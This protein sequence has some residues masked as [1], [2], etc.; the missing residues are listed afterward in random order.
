MSDQPKIYIAGIGMITA[1]G[2]HTAMTAAAVRA[3]VSG[4]KA[5]DYLNQKGQPI[6]MARVPAEVFTSPEF[7]IDEGS[8]PSR[9]IIM[10]I[11]ALREALA[12]Q[13][14]QQPIPLILALPEKGVG[15]IEPETLIS[16]LLKQ[17][18]LPLRADRVQCIAGGRAAGIQGL[19]WAIQHLEQGADFVLLGGSDSY[20]NALRIQEL[21]KAGRL[22]APGSKD[23]F[24]PGEA[25]G[26]LLLT[27]HP[28][29]ALT[30]G[31]YIRGRHGH[32]RYIQDKYA[33]DGHPQNEHIIGLSA[34]GSS[35]EPGH[36][37][38][39]ESYRGDGLD[40]AFKQ[41]L[42]AYTGE[43]IRTIYS[44]M[45]GEHHWAKEYGVAFIRNQE[46]FHD[47]VH[48][49]HPADC[50]GDLGS[51]TGPIFIGLAAVDLFQLNQPGPATHLVYSSSD[52]PA[53]AA[54]RVEK[55]ARN[56][57]TGA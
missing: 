42:N 28:Q 20:G 9:L 8:Y 15:T 10:A 52:G 26:F 34:P 5:C 4:Y 57:H 36:L 44:S 29:K 45:N 3:G 27:R 24:V 7:E 47:P 22:L 40:R 54:V 2:A 55:L 12:S 18:D 38:S 19:G 53:R 51:A 25:A 6:T 43:G 16:N 21:D 48:I 23:G 33:R 50:F 39:H 11:I 32:D 13:S 31:G 37:T 1:I 14:I 56:A 17:K 30:Q 49:E 46:H 35:Q 41:T